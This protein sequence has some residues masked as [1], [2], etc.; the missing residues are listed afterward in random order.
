[1]DFR[2]DYRSEGIGLHVRGACGMSVCTIEHQQKETRGGELRTV[3]FHGLPLRIQA[4]R[5]RVS[6][7]F[8]GDK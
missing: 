8:G 3:F 4:D 2:D 5:Q 1:M 7:V 6:Q